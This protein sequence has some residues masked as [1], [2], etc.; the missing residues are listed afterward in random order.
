MMDRVKVSEEAFEAAVAGGLLTREKHRTI[1]C[2][3]R[4]EMERYI[5][6]IYRDGF[7]DGCNAIYTAVADEA[8][9]K[10]SN[11]DDEYEEIKADWEDVLR[12]IGEVKGT[13]PELLR[14]IDRKLR[15][16]F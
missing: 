1:K 7:E 14:D 4:Q 6:S 8:A 15:E 3:S 2:F 11:P 10:H 12:L 9:A 5:A 13:T 16:A